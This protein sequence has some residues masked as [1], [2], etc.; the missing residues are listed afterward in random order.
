[1]SCRPSPYSLMNQFLSLHEEVVLSHF[2]DS[3]DSSSRLRYQ[4]TLKSDEV[5]QKLGEETV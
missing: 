3:A 5:W 4:R 1:M 2:A